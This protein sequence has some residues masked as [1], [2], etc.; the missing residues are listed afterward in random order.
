MREKMKVA[1][2]PGSF[3]PITKGHLDIIER[4]AKLFDRLII[5]VMINPGKQPMFD[6][7]ERVRLIRES[8][9]H[10]EQVEVVANNGLLIDF[11]ESVGASFIV[12]GLRAISDFEAEFQM[13]SANQKLNAKIETVFMMTRVEY[14]YLSSSIVKEVA[15]FGGD[16]SNFVTPP[17][18]EAVK[19]RSQK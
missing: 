1:V 9:K 7:T 19:K 12:K 18:A 15:G 8:T 5:V 14:M 17:V 10:I 2:Y 6:M 13:A 16:I 3:D 11:A 4:S